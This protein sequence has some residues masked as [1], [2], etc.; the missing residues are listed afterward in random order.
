LIMSDAAA[1]GILVLIIGWLIPSITLV[2]IVAK[3]R[4]G[5]WAAF[6]GWM[7]ISLLMSPLLALL[8]L[9][10]M[11]AVRRD[12]DDDRIPCPYCAEDIKPEAMLCPHCRSD[13]TKGEVQRLR[14][15]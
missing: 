9:A 6:F 15:R 5:S 13:L 1:V 11:P 4:L 7:I 10:A 12:D 14:P 3:A 8:G 2:P